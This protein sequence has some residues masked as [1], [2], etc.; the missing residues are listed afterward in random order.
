MN[1]LSLQNFET[2]LAVAE[3]GSFTSAA[4]VL[5][6]S[7]AAVSQTIRSLEESLEIPLFIRST[8]RIS[9]T[10]E[11]ELFFAQCQRLRDELD[12]TRN[13]VGKFKQSPSGLLRISCNA[14]I[15]ETWLV[16][17]LKPYM[18]KYPDVH[19][20]ILIQERMPDMQREHIDIVFGVNCP[21]TDDVVVRTIS[22]TRYVLC[23]SPSY[24]KKRGVPQS[25]KDLEDHHYIP[26]L[27]RSPKNS[28]SQLKQPTALNIS[29]RLSINNAYIMKK[30]AELGYGIVQLHEYLVQEELKNGTLV[31]ILKKSLHSK[32]SLY[33]YYQKHRFV[34]PKIRQ[35][36][37]L[38]IKKLSSSHT[39]G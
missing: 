4:E 34:Q 22:K 24:L 7:K 15:A 21:A 37:N 30:C 16:H 18:D 17:I 31:E 12:I 9:L 8:R 38:A 10:D 6:I 36:V 35:F 5:G 28:V 23:A 11:G 27:G 29:P 32:I 13:L 3:R 20:E 33:M 26:H 25:I 39:M 14:Y 19:L 2:F 1:K